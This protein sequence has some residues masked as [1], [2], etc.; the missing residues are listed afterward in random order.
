VITQA[1][2]TTRRS[3]QRYEDAKRFLVGGVSGAG[4]AAEPYPIV[5]ASAQGKWLTDIDGNRYLDYHGG[6]GSAVLGYAH[7]EVDAAVAR[8]MAQLSTFVGAPH[9]RE[10][11]LAERLCATIPC[12]ERVAFCGGGGSD[13]IYHAIRVARQATGRTKIIRVEG[14]YHGWQ[15]DIAVSSRPILREPAYTGHP[16]ATPDS[17]GVLEAVT[18]EV[19]V[20][21]ANDGHALRTTF[22]RHHEE[23][24]GVILEPVSYSMGCVVLDHAYVQLA[25]TLCSTHHAVLIFDEVLTGFRCD[26]RGLGPTLEVTPD[27]AAYGKAIANGYVMSMLAGRGELME[28]LT[29]VGPVYYA[30]TFNAHPLSMAAAAMTLTV[31]QRDAIPDR[32][33]ALGERLSAKVNKAID[34][35]RV[36]VAFQHYGSI[37]SI[38]F[39]AR[40]V[41]GY[42]DL[43]APT[44]SNEDTLTNALRLF[45][46]DRG[47]YAHN[48]YV[49]RCCIS[50]AHDENDI[51][52]TAE[53]IAD[54]LRAHV[55]EL[56]EG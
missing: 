54:F 26:I 32:I 16:T 35:L 46:L 42:R 1:T 25:R 24:A 28:Q 8:E 29:P 22:E 36:P 47:I 49:F 43:G 48:R 50:A 53:S 33:A 23:I 37:W 56:R 27:L 20:V 11:L 30:G 40:S 13:A 52:W 39:A 44:L 51:D 17:A 14:G 3:Q 4:R 6:L 19:L 38:F 34:E 55:D 45:L 21:S 7:P 9:A 2:Q 41:R 15:G 5:I 12:A 10:A 31:L 18:Q